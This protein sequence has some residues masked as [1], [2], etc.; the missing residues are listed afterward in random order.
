MFTIDLIYLHPFSDVT[1]LRSLSSVCIST[2]EGINR[3]C[4][5]YY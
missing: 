4:T 1:N 3:S 5:N 2:A